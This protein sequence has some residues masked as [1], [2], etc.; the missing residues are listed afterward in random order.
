VDPGWRRQ[1]IFEHIEITVSGWAAVHQ[2]EIF[3]FLQDGE[4][5][6]EVTF[7]EE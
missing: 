1:A 3:G 5:T 2:V 6:S 4:E 7:Q